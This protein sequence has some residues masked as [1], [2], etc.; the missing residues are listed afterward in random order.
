MIT[1]LIFS[2]ILCWFYQEQVPYKPAETFEIKID[3][4]FKERLPIDQQKVVYDQSREAQVRKTA[5]GPMPYLL[6]EL[7]ILSVADNEARVRVLNN[8]GSL[9][10]N[11]KATSGMVIKLDWGYTEDIKDKLTAHQFT[12]YFNDEKKKSVSTI[13]LTIL[14]D[15]VFMVNEEKRGKF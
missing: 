2:S 5:D 3:Y 14:D 4:I 9:V 12:V 8:S 10:F 7:K 13:L 6:I 11:R 1:N 15:G